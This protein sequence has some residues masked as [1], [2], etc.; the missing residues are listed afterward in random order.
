MDLNKKS[1]SFN[2][3][4]KRM[5]KLIFRPEKMDK[6]RQIIYLKLRQIAINVLILKDLFL[7]FKAYFQCS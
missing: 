4:V 5:V 2:K 1:N 3:I 6:Y 7:F